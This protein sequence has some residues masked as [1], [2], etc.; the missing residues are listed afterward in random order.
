MSFEAKSVRLQQTK[1]NNIKTRE[2]FR[3]NSL[4]LTVN[5]YARV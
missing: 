4:F 3:G 2:K 1:N 5:N